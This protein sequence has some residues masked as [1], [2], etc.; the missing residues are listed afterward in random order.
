MKAWVIDNHVEEGA[1]LAVLQ[2]L[3]PRWLFYSCVAAKVS[4]A[5]SFESASVCFSGC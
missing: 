3:R 2:A 1:Y 4:I 5:K